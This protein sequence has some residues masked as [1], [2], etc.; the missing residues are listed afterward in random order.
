MAGKCGFYQNLRSTSFETK[1]IF[2]S[3][4]D[5]K[6]PFPF[7]NSTVNSNERVNVNSV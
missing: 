3:L 5:C 4:G 7:L 2:H 6:I 1:R